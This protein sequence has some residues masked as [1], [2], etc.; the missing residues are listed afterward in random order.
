M[1]TPALRPL[2][3]A[4]IQ[5]VV[6]HAGLQGGRAAREK[7]AA[8][9]EAVATQGGFTPGRKFQGCCSAPACAKVEAW[10]RSTKPLAGSEGVVPAL[11]RR[12]GHACGRAHVRR[13]LGR[14]GALA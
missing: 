1:L 9:A 6:V 14:H 2:D 12:A 10:T 11:R 7:A 13:A 5:G 3:G 8:L 4:G